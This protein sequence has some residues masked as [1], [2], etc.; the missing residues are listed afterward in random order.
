MTATA[1]KLHIARTYVSAAE[2]SATISARRVIGR[3]AVKGQT[4]SPGGQ[5]ESEVDVV[6]IACVEMGREASPNRSRKSCAIQRRRSLPVSV[7]NSWLDR[8][9]GKLVQKIDGDLT[10]R[11]PPGV[12]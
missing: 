11:R 6:A 12:K 7:A 1:P 3:P 5:A 9:S 2:N 4:G 10:L 8:G